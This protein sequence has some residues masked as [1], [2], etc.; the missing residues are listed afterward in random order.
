[1]SSKKEYDIPE[2]ISDIDV[3]VRALEDL[4]DVYAQLPFGYKRALKASKKAVKL[5][6]LFWEKVKDL[7]PQLDKDKLL[8]ERER[9]KLTVMD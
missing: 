3:E 8:Y 9:K 4:R 7:Y 1:M 6:F 5:N 2:E